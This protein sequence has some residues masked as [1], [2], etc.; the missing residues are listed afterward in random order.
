MSTLLSNA[1]K[2]PADNHL[3]CL[4]TCSVDELRP[5]PSL[6]RLNIVPSAHDLSAAIRQRDQ[7]IK[8]PLTITRDRYILAGH[9]QWNMACRQGDTALLCLQLDMTEEEALLWLIQKHQRS[10]SINDFSRILLA[11]ELEPWFK[12]RARSN[13]QAGGKMKGS[14]NLTEADKLDVRSEIATAAGVSVGNV[15]K[16]KRLL[17]EGA[18][19]LLESLRE[20]EVSIHCASVWLHN[21]EKQLDQL[22]LHQNRRGITKTI[23]SLQRRHR[24]PHPGKDGPLDLQRIASSLATMDSNPKTSVLVGEIQAPGKVLL[25]STELLQALE[26]QGELPL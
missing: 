19:G 16:V 21:S 12:A 3:G 7:A 1:P 22:R 26:S 2:A 23:R 15:S 14:S 24:L 8:E 25:L 6:V 4:I 10:S 13:Q 17:Q 5:H 9:A 11:L 20:G 18:P